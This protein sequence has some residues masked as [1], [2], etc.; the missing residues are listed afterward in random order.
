MVFEVDSCSHVPAKPHIISLC[1]QEEM[2]T[3]SA[4]SFHL[5]PIAESAQQIQFQYTG[6]GSGIPEMYQVN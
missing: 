5:L 2:T 6:G 4:V 1:L 3:T